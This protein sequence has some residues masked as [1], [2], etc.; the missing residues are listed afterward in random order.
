MHATLEAPTPGT[1]GRPGVLLLLALLSLG[2]TAAVAG[3]AGDPDLQALRAHEHEIDAKLA[4]L[5]A[6]APAEA[7]AA[8]AAAAPG[9]AASTSPP[10]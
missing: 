10:Q 2:S 5:A 6:N 9:A 4:Q 8:V 7:T 3:T 1:C